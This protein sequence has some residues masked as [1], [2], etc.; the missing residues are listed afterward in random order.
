MN[1]LAALILAVLV[2]VLLAVP[3]VADDGY[4]YRDGYYWLHGK[5]YKKEQYWV[6]GAYYWH[7]GYQYQYP[8]SWQWRYVEYPVATVYK[9]TYKEPTV[10]YKDKDW[11]NRLL[12]IAENRDK[13]E[14]EIRKGAF[15]QKYFLDAV[16]SLGLTGNFRWQNY[17]AGPPYPAG[18]ELGFSAGYGHGAAL[19]PLNG[20]YTQTGTYQ[21]GS[22]GVNA[23]TVYGTSAKYLAEAYGDTNLNQLYQ[24]ANR[25]AENAQKLGGDA[26]S[27]FSQLVREEGSNK[28]RVAEIIARAEALRLMSQALD[29]PPKTFTETKSV[30]IKPD[31]GGD[32]AAK[33][34]SA[35]IRERFELSWKDNCAAC[36]DGPKA[37]GGFTKEVFLKMSKKEQMEHVFPLFTT[38]DPD[39]MMP[40]AKDGGPGKRMSDEE[41]KVWMKV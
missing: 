6:P 17:G 27:N 10:T 12:D 40:R 1:K 2:V 25:L 24:Q 29:G 38:P 39:K 37:K 28:A 4:V 32:D 22:Y 21:L 34:Q 23:S 5:A 19:L 31:R 14:A 41:I 35:L 16:N 3:A 13:H 9:E 26:T 15:E 11:R 8:G 30:E 7:C 36:H 18:G 20:L 33:Q